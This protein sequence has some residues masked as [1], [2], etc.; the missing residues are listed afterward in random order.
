MQSCL[1]LSHFDLSWA[2]YLGLSPD[3]LPPRQKK[4]EGRFLGVEILVPPIM[5]LF[6]KYPPDTIDV[7]S[8]IGIAQEHSTHPQATV[9]SPAVPQF[10][11]E[12]SSVNLMRDFQGLHCQLSN[13]V[14]KLNKQQFLGLSSLETQ[15]RKAPLWHFMINEM[16][17]MKERITLQG[18]W[19]WRLL[20]RCQKEKEEGISRPRYNHE[21]PQATWGT[22]CSL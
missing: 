11:Q 16:T 22:V 19:C 20:S 21:K 14:N 12:A 18:M 10:S 8:N 6:I 4:K 13:S 17:V 7:L 2:K 3:K 1:P 15:K 5:F 9:C